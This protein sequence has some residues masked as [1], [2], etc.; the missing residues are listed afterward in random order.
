MYPSPLLLSPFEIVNLLIT[1]ACDRLVGCDKIPLKGIIPNV[2]TTEE[3][4]HI[5]STVIIGSSLKQH[6]SL[7]G[8]N[9]I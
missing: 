1:L 9:I 8:S 6:H 3:V 2:R 5:L 4:G 7:Y